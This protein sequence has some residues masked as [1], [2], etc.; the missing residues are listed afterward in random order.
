MTRIERYAE[1]VVTAAISIGIINPDLSVIR[2]AA[3]KA[4]AAALRA[5]QK[6]VRARKERVK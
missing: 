4:V 6:S 3:W 2:K 5:Q 1:R